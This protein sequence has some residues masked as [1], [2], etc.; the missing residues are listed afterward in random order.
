MPQQSRARGIDTRPWRYSFRLKFQYSGERITLAGSERV[1]VIAP[2]SVTAQPERGKS[3]G[4]WFEVLDAKGNVLF[5]RLLRDPLRT[6]V[7]VFT[8]DG[9][10]RRITGPPNEGEFEVVVPDIPEAAAIVLFGSVPTSTKEREVGP[11]RELGRFKLPGEP[12]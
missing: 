3:S 4:F 10:F 1:Q 2:P 11:A 5:Y 7:E 9:S 8:A 12:R 6:A